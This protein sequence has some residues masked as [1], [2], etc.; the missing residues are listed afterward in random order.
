[1]PP[2]RGWYRFRCYGPLEFEVRKSFG[3]FFED[4]G[5]SCESM[6][7][8][9]ERPVVTKGTRSDLVR[10][11][12][13]RSKAVMSR[14]NEAATSEMESSEWMTKRRASEGSAGSG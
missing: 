12:D 8:T 10:T 4:F 6:A 3:G 14:S 11:L 2:L 7:A 13:V 1:M 5:V 9:V